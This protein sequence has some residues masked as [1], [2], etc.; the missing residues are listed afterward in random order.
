[1]TDRISAERRSRNMA[2]IHGRN[3]KPE[4]YLRHELFIRGFR[5]RNNVSYI[6]GHPDIYLAKYNIA[7]F[8][9]GCFWH[10]HKGCKDAAVPKSH[11][12]FWNEKFRKNVLRDRKVRKEILKNGIRY[13]VVWECTIRKMAADPSYNRQIMNRINRLIR[14][15]NDRPQSIEF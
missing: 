13:C 8:V 3:T 2:A 9:N 4:Q 12:E 10:R 5:Y 1:M 7:I 14:H 15:P 11:A 6:C